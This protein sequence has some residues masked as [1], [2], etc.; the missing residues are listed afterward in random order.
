MGLCLSRC[1]GETIVLGHDANAIT[2]TVSSIQRGRVG[3]HIVAP[4]AVNI[5]RGELLDVPRDGSGRR[6]EMDADTLP[7]LAG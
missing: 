4:Q 5:A 6:E 7:D 1:I 2:I 3:L